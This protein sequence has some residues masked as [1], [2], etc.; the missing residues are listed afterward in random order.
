[1][2]QISTPHASR[3]GSE[4]LDIE[5]KSAEMKRPSSELRQSL[6]TLLEQYLYLLDRQQELQ[7]GLSQQLA[8][9]FLSLAHANYTCPPGRR[10]GADY[11]DDRMKATR[12][13][14]VQ[15]RPKKAHAETTKLEDKA[16]CTQL[17]DNDYWLAMDYTPHSN[18]EQR[19]NSD[20]GSPE[21]RDSNIEDASQPL[22][23]ALDE[24][25]APVHII[26]GAN[27]P[28]KETTT[29]RFQSDNPIHWYGIL[30]PSSL[31]SAQNAFTDGIQGHVPQL[32]AITMKMR[33]LEQQIT[34]LQTEL[35]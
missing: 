25:E 28:R 27:T 4:A 16:V 14:S 17:K 32:A 10:Y 29:P 3:P 30:V 6:D 24:N 1:M 20:S 9:G 33:A 34:H 22:T 15:T 35:A 2:S 12:K 26:D 31:R 8:S 7:S 19:R 13:I 23:S 18:T 11:Y 21:P 5:M